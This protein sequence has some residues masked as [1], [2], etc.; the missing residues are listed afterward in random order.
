MSRT[1]QIQPWYCSH[2]DQGTLCGFD[3]E[4]IEAPT[5]PLL[6]QGARFLFINKGEGVLRL[7]NTD[8]PL[9]PGALVAILPWQLSEMVQVDSPLAYFILR[10]QL[11]TVNGV[12]KSICNV[13]SEPVRLLE[14][15]ENS[16]V[17]YCQGRDADRIQ[18]L[19]LTLQAETQRGEGGEADSPSRGI[20]EISLLVQLM[21]LFQR[22]GMA[23]DG[24]F[25]HPR[26]EV[27][28][29]EIFR[30]L[31]THLSEKITL[32]SLSG[33]FYLSESAIRLYIRE[34]TG[35]SFFDLLGEMRVAKTI[36][37]LLYTDLTLEELAQILGYVDASHISKVF[38]A[39]M[40]MRAGE[41]RRTYQKAGEICKI[42][43]SR[44]AYDVVAWIYRNH[45]E[46][47]TVHLVAERFGITTEELHKILLYQ[48]EK[49]FESFLNYVR[50]LHA[51]QLLAET[52]TTITAIA[53]EV[54]YNTV[55]SFTRNFL[56]FQVM[57]PSR[58]RELAARA[59]RETAG[60]WKA[61]EKD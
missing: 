37:F 8:Y 42:K 35:L 38:A 49:N 60:D 30:Y 20:Y 4:V 3:R 25:G 46:P 59:R 44:L 7:Q 33:I 39:R 17:I 19:L 45:T 16:P 43:E 32:K 15:M 24:K 50:V 51:S 14:E 5:Q 27:D 21:V 28:K 9:R 54:G 57:T 58:Y 34:M 22:I 53:M 61:A 12:I 52:D 6:H 13:R 31:Y 11:D 10:Y 2:L 1:V 48:V 47:L 55:K 41:Y 26:Q 23:G 56:R 29:S 18:Q 36:N 40:G